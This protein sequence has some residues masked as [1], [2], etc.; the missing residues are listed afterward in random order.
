MFSGLI[1]YSAWKRPWSYLDA[2]VPD[3]VEVLVRHGHDLIDVFLRTSWIGEQ[4]CPR[5]G[6]SQPKHPK[7]DTN[8]KSASTT[9][10]YMHGDGGGVI[11]ARQ[12]SEK[13]NAEKT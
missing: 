13:G 12:N 3:H 5:Y 6:E 1:K 9:K 4:G 2:A 11:R 10:A 7:A 8:T